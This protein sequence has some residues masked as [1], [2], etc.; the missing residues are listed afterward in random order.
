MKHINRMVAD[1]KPK[2]KAKAKSGTKKDPMKDMHNYLNYMRVKAVSAT[3]V[4]RQHAQQAIDTLKD[5]D[6]SGKEQFLQ[7]F[8]ET[9][10]FKDLSWAKNFK[11]ELSLDKTHKT[12][13]YTHLRA[14]ET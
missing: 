10:K 7:K 13:S 12:V 8:Q 11:S 6:M 9:K 4:E 3:A 14:H 1:E 5:L 2:A